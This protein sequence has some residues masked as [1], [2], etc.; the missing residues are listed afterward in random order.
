MYQANVVIGGRLGLKEILRDGGSER[1]QAVVYELVF[2]AGKDVMSH[3]EQIA[4]TVDEPE[5]QHKRQCPEPQNVYSPG[6]QLANAT[7]GVRIG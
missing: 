5:R 7:V 2:L 4:I 3:G 1:E 6:N